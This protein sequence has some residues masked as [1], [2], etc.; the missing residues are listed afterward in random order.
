[1]RFSFPRSALLLMVL[2]VIA[3][4]PTPWTPPGSGWLDGAGSDEGDDETPAPDLVEPGSSSLEASS[5]SRLKAAWVSGDDGSRQFRGWYDTQLET[6]CQFQDVENDYT[7]PQCIP[8]DIL[9]GTTEMFDSWSGSALYTDPS[10]SSGPPVVYVYDFSECV[11]YGVLR[12]DEDRTESLGS[13]PQCG[14]YQRLNTVTYY[15][16]TVIDP[17]TTTLYRYG[18]PDGGGACCGCYPVD[19][20]E[21]DD[22][23]LVLRLGD[24]LDHENTPFATSSLTVDP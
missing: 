24:E 8:E 3:C 14:L 6:Y 22:S 19:S 16:T 21:I 20:S 23:V 11:D 10:C 18:V 17:A 7:G 5:G 13:L 12:I 1:M 9:S 15:T 2:P 4:G